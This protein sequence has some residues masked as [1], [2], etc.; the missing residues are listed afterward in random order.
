MSGSYVFS[1][2]PE[3]LDITTHPT[4]NTHNF[5]VC[6]SILYTLV[7]LL[8]FIYVPP[9]NWFKKILLSLYFPLFLLSS[10]QSSS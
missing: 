7:V 1:L 10:Y 6:L 4:H 3:L 9:D 5:T 8:C 2:L